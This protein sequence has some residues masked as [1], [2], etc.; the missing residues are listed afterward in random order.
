MDGTLVA[1]CP[2][3]RNDNGRRKETIGP[4]RVTH[5]AQ[6]GKERPTGNPMGTWG[7]VLQTQSTTEGEYHLWK[8]TYKAETSCSNPALQLRDWF[9][10]IA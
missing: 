6:H 9:T 10:F 7:R 8:I 4:P 3:H 2:D 5:P 1:H